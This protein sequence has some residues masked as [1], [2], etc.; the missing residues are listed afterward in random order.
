MSKHATA[1][2]SDQY[3]QNMLAKIQEQG[4]EIVN[5]TLACNMWGWAC[6][7][8]V[9]EANSGSR[10]IGREEGATQSAALLKAWHRVA[11]SE[12]PPF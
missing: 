8:E 2:N 4:L 12:M 6:T 11:G 3:I 5:L 7:L 9:Y 10:E 1:A